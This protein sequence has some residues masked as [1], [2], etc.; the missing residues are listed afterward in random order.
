MAAASA[1][2]LLLLSLVAAGAV[3]VWLASYEWPALPFLTLATV[4]LTY[5]LASRWSGVVTFALALATWV[6]PGAFALLRGRFLLS[7]LTLWLAA[8][9]TLVVATSR[10]LRW[11]V[12][13]RWV[14][15]IAVW[16]LVVSVSWPVVV[17]REAELSMTLLLQGGIPSSR[18]GGTPREAALWITH[19]VM[20]LGA[21]LLW[22]DWLFD[23]YP[24]GREGSFAREVLVG[25]GAGWLV[26]G[27]VAVYQV[28]V[29]FHFMNMSHWGFQRRA[30]GTL[31]DANPYG[32]V[33][34]V[35]GPAIIAA[36]WPVTEPRR[37][38]AATA[39]RL[40]LSWFGLWA[41]G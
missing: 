14:W 40:G 4:V 19:V 16:A 30:A 18:V 33:A 41:S 15:P 11:H 23:R 26:A 25:F 13:A 20:V 6:A 31:M 36:V 29:D 35:G 34:A 38:I 32:L 1:K 21:G 27:L 2:L 5:V 24:R 22:F 10:P 3:N 39:R 28:T 7:D 37:A 8:V 9:V 12:P 17:A